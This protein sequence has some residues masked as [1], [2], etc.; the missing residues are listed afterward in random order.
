MDYANSDDDSNEDEFQHS[1][2]K[3]TKQKYVEK[4][5][6]L[7]D[8]ERENILEDVVLEAYNEMREYIDNVGIPIFDHPKAK[9]YL[10]RYIKYM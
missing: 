10:Y 7:E 3:S 4:I 9:I 6:S 8:I 1:S 5:P 2:K